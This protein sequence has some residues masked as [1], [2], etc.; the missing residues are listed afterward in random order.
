MPEGRVAKNAAYLVS[1]FV[2]QK[3]LA[4]IYFTIVARTVGVQGAGRYFVALAFTTLFSIFIDLGMSNVMVRE[5]AKLPEKAGRLLATALGVKLLLA[6]AT[7]AV[8]NGCA[9]LLA[10][11]GET[12]LMIAIGSI[13][14]ALD[15]FHLLFYAVMRGFQNLRYEAIGV[16][17]GQTIIIVS[18]LLFIRLGLPLPWLVVALLLNSAWNVVWSSSML[19]RR[20][21]VAIGVAWEPTLLKFLWSVTVPFA[22]AGIFSRIYSYVDSVI[23]S[24]LASEQTVGF[25]GTAYKLAFAFQFLPMAFA[26]AVYPAMSD[27]Y[28]RDRAKLAAVYAKSLRYLALA[29]LPLAAGIAVLAGPIV[30]LV[31]GPAFAGAILPLRLLIISLIFAFLYWPAGSLLNAAD[32]QAENTAVMGVTM[33]SNVLL[34]FALVPYFGAVGAAIAALAGNCLLFLGAVRQT[35]AVVKLE[36][37]A[38]VSPLL[39]TAAAAL[40]MAAVIW[41][42]RDSTALYLTVPTGIA[43]Y[44][45][46]IILFRVVTWSELR[47]IAGLF[48]HRGR[49]ISD[50]MT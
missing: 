28:V 8:T 39:K 12:R 4:F 43:V 1:A 38:F 11:P 25:Y 32:R 21:G 17:S 41:P 37:A 35:R 29:V 33:I 31:Y 46:A 18:G 27:Y 45:T 23:L 5:T 14:A 42:W 48:L 44:A 34:N 6:A 50:L 13:V 9:W 3:V 7:I 40:A 36:R 24:K 19:R 22:L 30:R 20:C 49:G 16:L 10:Y 26:A 2:G 47:Q 15:S